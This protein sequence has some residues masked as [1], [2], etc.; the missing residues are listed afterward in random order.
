MCIGVAAQGVHV[1]KAK[2]GRLAVCACL[3]KGE[4][5]DTLE[6]PFREEV[7]IQLLNQRD[8]AGIHREHRISFNETKPSV[9][10]ER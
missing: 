7:T 1:S 8:D 4:N 10:C 6:W 5:D 9:C 3:M 2:G